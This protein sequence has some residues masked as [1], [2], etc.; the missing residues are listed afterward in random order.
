MSQGDH[1]HGEGNYRASR[2]YND[3]TKR[4]VESGRVEQAAEDAAPANPQEAAELENAEAAGRR[5]AKEEDP[6]LRSG[7]GEAG[8][9]KAGPAGEASPRDPQGTR[10]TDR[11]ADQTSTPAP[12]E[13]S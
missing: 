5:R 12:G 8:S 10:I 3:R 13:G 11:P 6:Q 9:G 2:E 1:E 7:A 4:F